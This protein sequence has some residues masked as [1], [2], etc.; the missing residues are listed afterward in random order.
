MITFLGNIAETA[1]FAFDFGKH[2]SKKDIISLNGELGSGKTVFVNAL[3][4]Y[5]E[6]DDEVCSPTFTIVNEY[7][8]KLCNIYHFDVYRIKDEK[9]FLETIGTEYFENGICIIEWGDIIKG[10]LPNNTIHINITKINDISRK[11]VIRRCL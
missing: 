7:N 9:Q 5:F 4:K 8:S 2:L 6:V 3:S 10:I 11:F 1:Q